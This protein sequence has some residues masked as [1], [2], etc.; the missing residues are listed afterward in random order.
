MHRNAAELT[1]PNQCRFCTVCPRSSDPFHI[2]RYYIKR[3]TTTWTHS[4]LMSI[5]NT[6]ERLAMVA[7]IDGYFADLSL[8]LFQPVLYVQ[9][10]LTLFYSKLLYKMV[11]DF[12]AKQYVAQLDF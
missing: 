2:V 7:L 4:M 10:I 3:V 9:D 6:L 12:L 11:Q 1:K 5:P 8:N